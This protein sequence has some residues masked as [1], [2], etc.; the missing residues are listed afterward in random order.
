[1]RLAGEAQA[2]IALRRL[3]RELG[4]IEIEQV[5]RGLE[6]DGGQRAGRRARA[7]IVEMAVMM[8]RILASDILAAV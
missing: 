7:G 5:D 6:V 4:R 1:L 3:D 2:R 8:E